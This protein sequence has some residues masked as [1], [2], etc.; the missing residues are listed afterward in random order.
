MG[1]FMSLVKVKVI[2]GLWILLICAPGNSQQS[3]TDINYAGDGYEYHNLDIHLPDGEASAFPV[4]VVIYGSAWSANNLKSA[5]YDIL[6]KQLLA[7]GYG[8]VSVNHRSSFDARY[9]AQLQDIKAAIRFVRANAG[10]YNLDTAFIGITGYS[11]GGHLAAMAG[12]TG[13]VNKYEAGGI[14]IDLEGD[15]GEFTGFSSSVDAVVDWFGPTDFTVMDS[16][17]SRMEHNAVDSPES[18]LV[19]GPIRENRQMCALADPTSYVSED[20]PPFLVLHGDA[21]PLVP[22]CQGQL[23]YNRLVE[24]GVQ[25]TF[26]LVPGA[27]HGPG[28]FVDE[29]FKM[30]I[31]F[32]N[33]QK[34]N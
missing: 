9:P 34:N 7:A 29:Y 12:T 13:R 14:K 30:M 33:E 21:D 17:G 27:G 25:A 20:D 10:K 11:S 28:L 2:T 1:I 32:F 23:L 26:I 19:G 22:H 18:R 5:A 8:V 4:V 31:D 3:W 6:G 16:C 15:I 24:Q